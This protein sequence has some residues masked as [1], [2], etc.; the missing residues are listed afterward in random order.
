LVITEEDDRDGDQYSLAPSAKDDIEA[1]LRGAEGVSRNSS[2]ASS[3]I[4]PRS[5]GVA[6]LDIRKSGGSGERWKKYVRSSK[7][8]STRGKDEDSLV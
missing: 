6:P 7:A 1:A 8:G 2:S 5:K 4:A 3:M